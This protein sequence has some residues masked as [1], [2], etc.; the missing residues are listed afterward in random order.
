MN[1]VRRLDAMAHPLS[2]S[3]WINLPNALTTLRLILVVPF[4]IALLWD[5]GSN[6]T[7]R[8]IATLIFIVASLTDYVDGYIARK[9]NLVTTFGKVADPIADKL[10]T[11]VALVG[12]SI[13]GELPWWVTVII[14]GRELAVTLMRFWVIREGV[15]AASRGGKWK[16]AT[17]ILAIVLFLLPLSGAAV[18]VAQVVMGV[19]VVLTLVTGVDYAFRAVALRRRGS[20]E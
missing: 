9:K 1:P 14:L 11:G 19:A 17:Q 8:I 3:G 16:T 15:M 12:L 4:G 2:D 20:Q 6:P 10:L 7:A 13:L 5:D 18:V